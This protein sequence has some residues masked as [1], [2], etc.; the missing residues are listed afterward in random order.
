M[1]TII[2]PKRELLRH[3]VS[4][5]AYRGS[6]VLRDAPDGFSSFRIGETTRT[7]AQI[8]AHTGDLLDWALSLAIGDQK[9][10]DSTP[11]PWEQ[12]VA[13]FFEGLKKLD[14]YLASDAA[15]G[16]SCEN[17]FQGPIADALT[18]VGQMA[19]LRR[20]AGRRVRGEN[21]LKAEIEVG[22]LGLEQSDKRQ[23]FERENETGKII[24]TR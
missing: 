18:H 17:I 16:R 12:E 3:T 11:L 6:K 13:R 24:F 19:M 1:S 23:E 8:L 2:D 7:P 10:C 22:R 21:Y 15:L 20:L 14:D 5:L 4:T 9:W